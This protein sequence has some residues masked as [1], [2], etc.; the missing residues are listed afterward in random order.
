MTNLQTEIETKAAKWK[1]CYEMTRNA[2]STKIFVLNESHFFEEKNYEKESLKVH[3]HRNKAVLKPKNE[4]KKNF[5]KK[6]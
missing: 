5:I 2:R 3:L 4:P 6:N 1:K